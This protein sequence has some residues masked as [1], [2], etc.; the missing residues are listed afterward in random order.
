M[1]SGI[2]KTMWGGGSMQRRSI[3]EEKAVH[4]LLQEISRIRGYPISKLVAL[5]AANEY[6]NIPEEVKKVMQSMQII[7]DTHTKKDEE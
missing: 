7:E 6:A 5:W 3:N 2:R 1:V 4:E